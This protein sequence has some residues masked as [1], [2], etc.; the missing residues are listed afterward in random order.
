MKRKKTAVIIENYHHRLDET[1][2]TS[3]CFSFDQRTLTYFLATSC[4]VD[5]RASRCF[6]GEPMKETKKNASKET[7]A[8][9]GEKKR[10]QT[11][12]GLFVVKRRERRKIERERERGEKEKKQVNRPK[13]R[14]EILS[15]LCCH[16]KFVE[17]D[18]QIR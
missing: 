14:K 17:N 11:S 6:C 8:A 3:S 18:V 4:C 5:R 9:D 16:S 13:W 10:S 12:F 2:R 1:K 7:E 15:F